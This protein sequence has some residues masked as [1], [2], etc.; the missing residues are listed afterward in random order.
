[1]DDFLQMDIFFVT[2]TGAVVVVAVLLALALYYVVRILR[3]VDRVMKNV[4]EESV[5]VRTDIAELRANVRAEGM[6]WKH[7]AQ[8]FGRVASRNASRVRRTKRS[9]DKSDAE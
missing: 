6:K 4:S 1:M 2:T 3:S 7:W 8:F 5:L 9:V